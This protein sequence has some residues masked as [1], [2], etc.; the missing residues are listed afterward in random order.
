MSLKIEN[1][2]ILGLHN[3]NGLPGVFIGTT[4]AKLIEKS[5][6][7]KL[8]STRNAT[9]T[10]LEQKFADFCDEL[11]R[12]MFSLTGADEIVINDLEVTVIPNKTTIE[13]Q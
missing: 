2:D 11:R 8:R 1:V 13:Q 4:A 7:Y 6:H 10:R 5:H 9:G 3:P 12:E